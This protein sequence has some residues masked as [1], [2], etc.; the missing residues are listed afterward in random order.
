MKNMKIAILA[1]AA[2][3]SL[4]SEAMERPETTYTN[5]QRTEN[6]IA[7]ERSDGASLKLEYNPGTE[8]YRGMIITRPVQRAGDRI[9]KSPGFRSLLPLEAQELYKE[10]SRV[11]KG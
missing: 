1:A 11:E 8:T 5:I 4:R 3:L 9:P 10:L 7:A 6:Q 2:V